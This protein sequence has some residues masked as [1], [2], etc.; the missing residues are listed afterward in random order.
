[1]F[2]RF[3]K[4]KTQ[5]LESLAN[6]PVG[7]PVVVENIRGVV[8]GS[9]VMQEAGDIW[10]EHQIE[11]QEGRRFWVSIENF[12]RT[13]ATLWEDIE[14]FDIQGG[15]SDN[16]VT[17]KGQSF[18]REEAGSAAF[19]AK[20]DVDMFESG[21]VDYVDFSSESGDRLGFERFGAEGAHR[22]SRAITG[23]CPNCGAPISVDTMGRCTSC[24]SEV[25]ADHGW[26]GSWEVAYG[27]NVTDSARLQ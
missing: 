24:S 11:N 8:R 27:R 2:G 10:I 25:M 4:D 22:R 5:G 12:D 19:T 13:E 14:V 16:R 17:Y 15:P 26:W 1:M 6:A 3:N 9:L 20:G 23:N 21:S 18:K 7:A